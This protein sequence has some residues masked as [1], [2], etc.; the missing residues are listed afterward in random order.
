MSVENKLGT[1]EFKKDTISHIAIKDTNTCIKCKEKPC[2]TSCPAKVYEW[3]E[4][5]NIIIVN[6]ENCIEC[7]A[8]VVICP[9][10]NINWFPPRGGFGIK[11]KYG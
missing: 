6:Y 7:G 2:L 11:Y 1:I 10:D 5:K 3:N 4:E 9:F 8:A